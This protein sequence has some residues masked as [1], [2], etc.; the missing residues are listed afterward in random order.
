M[1]VRRVVVTGIGLMTPCG[2]GW[3]PYWEALLKG[4]SHIRY[5]SN[6]HLNGFPSKLA[7]EVPAFNAADYVKKRKLLKVM[8][9]EIQLAVVASQLALDDARLNVDQTERLRFGVSLGA[10]LIN[11]DLE[12]LKLGIYKS[13]DEN[14]QFQ[15]RKFGQEGIRALFPLWFLKYLPNMPACH[16][17][18]AHG[19]KGPNNTVTTSAAAGAQAIGEALHVIQRGDA[20]IMLAGGTDSKV[21]PMGLSRFHL[22]GLLSI[23]NSVPPADVYCPF[24][25]RRDGLILGEGAGLLVLEEREHAL[26][27][28]ARIYGELLGY[29]SASDFNYDPR[30]S[31]DFM[32]KSLAM[33][34][35]LKHAGVAAEEIQGLLANGSGIPQDDILECRAIHAVFKRAVSNLKVTAVKPITGH[36]VYGSGGVETA[37]ALLSLYH[38][39]IPAVVN[40]NQPDPRCD[41][42]M[43]TQHPAPWRSELF[44]M[45]SFGF[46][47]QNAS[48]VMRKCPS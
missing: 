12:D 41:L 7:G 3:A 20:D 43:V 44:M 35:S 17:S 30:T 10:G 16:I 22:L 15:M 13:L 47:G 24:D 39:M 32:G 28:G 36:L 11:T 1:T 21:N 2:K 18:I 42:P 40:L 26:Q 48:L 5:L 33:E 23:R 34:R 29:G 8:S 19:L 27:R 31:E 9:R 38:E 45:N 4:E 14:G 37:A 46:G 6:F 25:E